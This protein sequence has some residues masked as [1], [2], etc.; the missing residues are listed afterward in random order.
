LSGLECYLID[1]FDVVFKSSTSYY[2][3]L[4]E[5]KISWQKA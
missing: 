5:A 1:H 3:L 2:E 4:K